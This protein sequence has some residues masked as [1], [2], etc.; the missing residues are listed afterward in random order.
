MTT[1][2]Q[3]LQKRISRAEWRFAFY[4]LGLLAVLGGIVGIIRFFGSL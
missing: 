1:R 4:F 2:Q 3:Q